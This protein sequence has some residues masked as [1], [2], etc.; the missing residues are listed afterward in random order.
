MTVGRDRCFDCFPASSIKRRIADGLCVR[1]EAILILSC[2]LIDHLLP[3]V[4]AGEI[5][6]YKK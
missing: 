5:R 2:R 4:V 6:T 3:G 1:P